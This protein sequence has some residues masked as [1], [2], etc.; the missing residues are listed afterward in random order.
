MTSSVEAVTSILPA[1]LKVI[2][3]MKTHCYK[4]VRITCKKKKTAKRKSS[5]RKR[6]SFPSLN[7]RSPV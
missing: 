1:E 2:T 3:N 7:F 6:S 5:S 4:K